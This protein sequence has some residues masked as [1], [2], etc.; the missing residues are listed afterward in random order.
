MENYDDLRKGERGAWLSI[1][2]YIFLAVLKIVVGIVGNSDA[3]QA[4]GLNNT[5]DIVAS[6]ALLIGLKISR[7]PP[8]EDHL[9]GHRRTETISS[10]IASFIMFLVGIEV[11][12]RAIVAFWHQEFVTPSMLTAIVALFSGIVMY[13]VYLI[14]N[15]L[16]KKVDSQAVKAAAYD[17]RS[18]AYVSFGTFIGITGAVVGLAWLDNVTALLVGLLIIY[19]AWKIFYDAAHTLTDGFDIGKI[20]AIHTIIADVPQVHQVLDIK[21][22]MNGNRIWIDATISVKADLNVAESHAITEKIETAI[23]ATYPN[24]YTLVHIEPYFE[25]KQ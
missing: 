17:N 11:V 16:A 4:D 8:D 23:R 22:R 13:V 15:N 7:I 14:N 24:A 21:A 18:D 1:I 25:E 10:L 2:A 12:W 6:V 19:T 3:L 5:T 9:Y 20:Q